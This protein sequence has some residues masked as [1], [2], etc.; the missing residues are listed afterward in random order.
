MRRCCFLRGTFHLLCQTAPSPWPDPDVSLWL[1]GPNRN[2]PDVQVC[3]RADLGEARKSDDKAEEN[4]SDE[5]EES[6]IQAV[7]LCPPSSIECMSVPMHVMLAWLSR[8]NRTESSDADI[9]VIEDKPIT[10]GAIFG[11]RCPLAW[12]GMMKS[13]LIKRTNE[14][15]P[16]DTLVLPAIAGGWREL[17]HI[18]GATVDPAEDDIDF[19]WLETELIDVSERAYQ[20]QR[21]R[22]IVRLFPARIECWP[23]NILPKDFVEFVR[24]P[25]FPLT[26]PQLIDLTDEAIEILGSSEWNCR[27]RYAHTYVNGLRQIVSRRFSAE[28]WQVILPDRAICERPGRRIHLHSQTF[29]SRR[30]RRR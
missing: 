29:G 17:G 19:P 1:H 21:Q 4:E 14:I 24:N 18:P 12:R 28:P 22:R 27:N 26:K 9:P 5:K 7:S 16:G 3:W 25:E 15:R 11:L 10:K 20:R 13:K 2:A 30:R 6:Y 8:D 23:K